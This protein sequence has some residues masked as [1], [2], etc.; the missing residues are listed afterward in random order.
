MIRESSSSFI[1][2]Q[3]YLNENLF[4]Q[5]F[6]S[7][8]ALCIFKVKTMELETTGHLL[9]CFPNKKRSNLPYRRGLDTCIFA[10]MSIPMMRMK[11]CLPG[12]VNLRFLSLQPFRFAVPGNG[13]AWPP[14]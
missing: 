14:I 7:M 5:T 12:L 1:L 10:Q 9:P 6:A 8:I 4:L 11:R 13:R 3:V 2:L